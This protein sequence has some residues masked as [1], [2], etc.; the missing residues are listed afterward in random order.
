MIIGVA[1]PLPGSRRSNLG[2]N[3]DS[4]SMAILS[5]SR[6][7]RIAVLGSSV[8]AVF[9]VIPAFAGMTLERRL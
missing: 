3:H 2:R 7:A 8:G 1:S 5:A 4:I 6:P 9:G